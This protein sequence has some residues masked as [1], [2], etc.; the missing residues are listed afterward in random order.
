VDLMEA[1]AEHEQSAEHGCLTSTPRALIGAVPVDCL[2]MDFAVLLLVNALWHRRER[3]PF[4]V[5][6]AN[7]WVV[8]LAE[9]NQSLQEALRSADMVLPDG[10][11]V[12]LA[13]RFLGSHIPERVTGGDLMEQMCAE[14]ARFGFRV[15]LLGGPPGVAA[16]AGANLARRYP[17]LKICGTYCPDPG[18]ENDPDELEHVREAIR[19]ASPDLLCVGLGSPK[20]EL[21]MRENRRLLDV[22]VIF[23]VGAALERQAGLRRRAPR[24]MQRM[25]LEWLFRLMLEPRRLWRRYL[26]GNPRFL[27]IVLRQRF[28]KNAGQS[29][30]SHEATAE[31]RL[32]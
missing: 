7:A 18:F 28:R 21:W 10:M 25:A 24:W 12:V 8:T 23:A 16:M 14:A 13:S 11:G 31:P 30:A 26:L 27:G 5:A 3:A 4:T 6:G 22:G 20:Q 17:G 32:R 19:E 29:V 9:K 1:I 2:S 15:F